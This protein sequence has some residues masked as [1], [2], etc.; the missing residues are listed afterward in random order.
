MKI[1]TWNV[2]SVK[3]RVPNMLRWIGQQQPDVLLLQ[4]LKCVDENFPEMEFKAEGYECAV[5]GQKSWNGVAI[6]SKHP[7]TDVMTGLPGD[8]TDA[9][10]RY[11]EATINGFRIASIYLPN[12]NPVDT[13][14][15]P[16]KL[17][18]FDR[19]IAQ[20]Q[21]LLASPLP[22][23]LGG[24]YNIIPEPRDCFDPAVW[25]NDALFMLPSRHKFRQLIN[26]GYTDAFRVFNQQE[27]QY[28]FW[29][30]QA[31]AWPR[32]MGIR[33]D[34]LLCSPK[35]ADRLEGCIIDSAPRG[36]EKAS[37]HTPVMASF[38]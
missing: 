15:Y 35:A 30:Y 9:Q 19:L 1:A 4:E 38:R 36:E 6:L 16:Y 32:N 22:V 14:K 7:I 20:A 3:I 29:D 23:V 33:I 10:S 17:N 28:S 8:P 11:I 21:N 13:E 18:F 12:G 34:H 26:M 2:N 27:H 5:F 25:K 37:D 24:D 31:G